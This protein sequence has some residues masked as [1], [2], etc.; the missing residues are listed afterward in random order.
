MLDRQQ[1]AD[2]NTP[3]P[4]RKNRR[5]VVNRHRNWRRV[6]RASAMRTIK[7][8]RLPTMLND[9]IS[10]L[11]VFRWSPQK[12]S[13]VSDRRESIER[14]IFHPVSSG[15]PPSIG[16][17]E[18]QSLRCTT[19]HSFS[20]QSGVPRSLTKPI[21]SEKWCRWLLVFTARIRQSEKSANTDSGR[22]HTEAYSTGRVENGQSAS[23]W[24]KSK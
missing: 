24:F 1:Q 16:S 3:V 18:Q 9:K 4:I 6:Q 20:H 11:V 13:I 19:W 15:V 10:P 17:L 14:L 22:M 5:P 7:K 2:Q 21:A 12:S 8:A 23:S